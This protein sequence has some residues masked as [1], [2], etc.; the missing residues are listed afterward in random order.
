MHTHALYV[1]IELV[2]NMKSRSFAWMYTEEL[3]SLWECGFRSLYLW[4]GF[5]TKPP[6]HTL[7]FEYL[8]QIKI[9]SYLKV[10]SYLVGFG[11]W[12]A[13][14]KILIVFNSLEV[15]GQASLHAFN[16]LLDLLSRFVMLFFTM[17][18]FNFQF[19]K[20][21]K[22][23]TA[24]MR[25][26]F[27]SRISD[28]GICWLSISSSKGRYV[29]QLPREW[30]GGNLK[31]EHLLAFD[32]TL[33]NLTSKECK[34]SFT[35]FHTKHF[36][37]FKNDCLLHHCIRHDRLIPQGL[38]GTGCNAQ[39]SDTDKKIRLHFSTCAGQWPGHE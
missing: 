8:L 3:G 5:S 37:H 16:W 7:F 11:K 15:F 6:F 18:L 29:G 32:C 28:L 26:C 13:V 34:I 23:F 39:L 4:V 1:G 19:Q 22:S 38:L 31:Y 27:S 35:K 12:H 25:L 20:L 9:D 2:Y 33:N 17:Q 21:I 10:E 30:R 24:Y 14:Y 36:P